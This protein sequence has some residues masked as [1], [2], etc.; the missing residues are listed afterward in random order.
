MC[1]WG[2]HAKEKRILPNPSEVQKLT[3]PLHTADNSRESTEF[4]G[5]INKPSLSKIGV[6]VCQRL[7]E[8]VASL[9]FLSWE[10]GCLLQARA[11]SRAWMAVGFLFRGAFS[12]KTRALQKNSSWHFRKGRG[13]RQEG[14]RSETLSHATSEAFQSSGV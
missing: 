4:W 6:N 14:R 12:N 10:A 13:K 7:C 2:D 1:A 5:K 8:Q 3:G 9:C 11:P